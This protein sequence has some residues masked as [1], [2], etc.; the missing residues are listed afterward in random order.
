MSRLDEID[1]PFLRQMERESP[2]LKLGGVVGRGLERVVLAE[3]LLQVFAWRKGQRSPTLRP[4]PWRCSFVLAR[5]LAVQPIVQIAPDAEGYLP[6]GGNISDWSVSRGVGP[7]EQALP[8]LVCYSN[9]WHPSLTL[10]WLADQVGRILVGEVLNLEARPLSLAGRDFQAEALAQG[11]LPTQVI[12][13][14]RRELLYLQTS[15]PQADG[16]EIEFHED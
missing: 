4:G 11:K 9:R 12:P 16:R 5:G 8:G 6:A 14:T 1:I 3:F 13:Y 15:V 7:S 2:W 10:P